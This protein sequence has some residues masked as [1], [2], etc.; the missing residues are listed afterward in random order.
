MNTSFQDNLHLLDLAIELERAAVVVI[1]GN[2]RAEIDTDIEGLAGGKG[3]RDAALGGD[4]GDLLALH[5]QEHIGGSPGP[6]EGGVD[7]DDVLEQEEAEPRDMSGG[8]NP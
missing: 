3:E 2:R 7:E 6:W 5:A 8:V 1:T 4:L